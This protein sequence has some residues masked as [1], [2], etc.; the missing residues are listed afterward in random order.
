M[1][2][3]VYNKYQDLHLHSSF[4]LLDGYGTVEQIVNRAL[5]LGRSSIAITDHGSISSHVKLEKCALLKGI[6]P[7]FGCEL[8]VVS[9]IADNTRHKSHIT[10]LAKNAE[11]YKNLLKLVTLGHENFYYKPTVDLKMLCENQKDLVFLSGCYSSM[12]NRTALQDRGVLLKLLNWMK[13]SFEY[14]YLEMQPFDICKDVNQIVFEINQQVG[15]PLCVTGDVHYVFKGQHYIQKML[16]CINQRATW[17]T[18]HYD[19]PE[20]MYQRSGEEVYN[21]CKR[22]NPTI[23]WDSA[24]NNVAI[25]SELCECKLSKSS[26]LGIALL[27]SVNIADV[28]M[29]GLVARG[30][31]SDQRYTERLKNELELIQSKQFTNYFLMLYDLINWAK[32][33]EILIG[34]SRG[35]SAGSLVCWVLGITE[36]DPIQHDLVFERFIDESRTDLPDIDVDIEE[37][38]RERMLEH[39]RELHG[40]E[41]IGQLATFAEFHGKNSLDEVGKIFSIPASVIG[42]IKP[43]VL[44]RSA[45]EARASLSLQDSIAMFPK[46]QQTIAAYPKIKTAMY[47]EGQLRHKSAHAA[48]FLISSRLKEY[49]AIYHDG[50]VSWDKYDCPYLGLLK[51]DLLS[52]HTLTILKN[53]ISKLDMKVKDLYQIALDDTK[54]LKGFDDLDVLGI[55]QFTGPSV[56][57]ILEEIPIARFSQLA[58]INALGRPG[59][60]QARITREYIARCNG[61]SETDSISPEYDAITKD[62]FGLAIYQE[63]VMQLVRQIGNFSW[64]DTNDIRHTMSQRLGE[65]VFGE[66]K[67]KFLDGAKHNGYDMAVAEMIW[68]RIYTFGAWAFNKSHAVGYSILAYWCMYFKQYHPVLFYWASIVSERDDRTRN[69]LISEMTRKGYKVFPPDINKSEFSWTLEQDGVR[70]GLGMIKGIGVKTIE[71]V[72]KHR[73]YASVDDLKSKCLKRIVNSRIVN[74]LESSGV[75]TD[76]FEFKFLNK[77]KSVNNST[78]LS[79]LNWGGNEGRKVKV[80]AEILDSSLY[81]IHEEDKIRGLHRTYASPELS[82]FIVLTLGDDTATVKGQIDRFLYPKYEKMLW[83]SAGKLFEFSGVFKPVRRRLL[84]ERMDL[85]NEH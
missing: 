8:H 9:K 39:L 46:M 49:C 55:F 27:K 18:V 58:D 48:G 44:Q 15:L 28:C 41:N 70:A 60:I 69:M 20:T 63:Q 53:I 75:L 14:M 73:P 80:Y 4:S 72:A 38:G 21:D 17:E 10:V 7:I 81:D 51:V 77:W 45:A 76:S 79:E 52:L 47:L 83:E 35:S 12:V 26:E 25:I 31:A 66:Y 22:N 34:P 59:P 2:N 33:S 74:I 56:R 43:L 61:R 68:N 30:M 1:T 24:F 37:S 5:D 65:K 36:V 71:E 42:S 64:K 67:A 54:V 16:Y 62:T 11:G 32:K 19:M 57:S 78:K 13:N 29:E 3:D 82:K 23:D 85:A 6:K 40:V 84:I 50:T